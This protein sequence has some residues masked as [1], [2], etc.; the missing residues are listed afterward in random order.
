MGG[1]IEKKADNLRTALEDNKR[2]AGQKIKDLDRLVTSI[3]R[4]I[5]IWHFVT[6]KEYV[7]DQVL[8][9]F[10][11]VCSFFERNSSKYLE[12]IKW[13]IECLNSYINGEPLPK[14]Y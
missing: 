11:Q 1:L 10:S 12:S 5:F 3:Y 8:P 13:R 4:G 14:N 7:R 2:P 9:L 6:E